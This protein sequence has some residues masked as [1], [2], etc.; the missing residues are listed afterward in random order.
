MNF[1]S[2]KCHFITELGLREGG[3]FF[4]PV[5]MVPKTEGVMM[6]GGVA[7][8][9]WGGGGCSGRGECRLVLLGTQCL[10]RR[11][12]RRRLP[13]PPAP[14]CFD[15]LAAAPQPQPPAV[16]T[17]STINRHPQPAHP[18]PT[19]MTISKA[20]RLCMS[21][22]CLNS[23][24]ITLGLH[25]HATPAA[26]RADGSGTHSRRGH[27]CPWRRPEPGPGALTAGPKGMPQRRATCSMASTN[28]RLMV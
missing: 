16:G 7:G 12:Q 17:P 20:K 13:W 21:R 26:G 28:G 2:P 14:C 24:S 27:A 23:C 5:A 11:L 1:F 4:I 10:Q 22:C 3:L 15:V 9:W 18:C 6:G 8:L 25:H 19:W